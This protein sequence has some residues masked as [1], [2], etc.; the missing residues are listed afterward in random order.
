MA[1]I[2]DPDSLTQGVVLAVADAAFTGSSGQNTVIGG[3]ATLPILA[4]GEWFEVR[5]SPL[6]QNNGLYE[7]TGTPTTSS[8]A[9]TKLGATAPAD[10]TAE[11]VSMLGSSTTPKNVMYDTAARLIYLLEDSGATLSADGLTMLALHSFTKEEWKADA[12]LIAFPFP[13]IGI[14]FDAGKWE[15]GVDPSGNA[16]GWR[17]E[18]TTAAATEIRSRLLVRNAGW[19]ERDSDNNIIKKYFNST[20]LGTF[21]D[22][23]DLAYYAFG[24]QPA[25][26]SSVNYAFT[27]PVNEA[28]KFFEEFGN[29]DTLNFTVNNTITRATGSFLTDGYIVGGGITIRA[30]ATGDHNGTF[31]VSTVAATSLTI[32]TTPWTTGLDTLALLS[33]DNSNA[34]TTFLRIRDADP[35]GKVFAQANL[36]SAGETSLVNKVIKF[37]LGNATDLK[38]TSTDAT[39]TGGGPWDEITLRYMDAVYQRDVDT[40]ATP[41]SFGIVVDVGTFSDGTGTTA[42]TTTFLGVGQWASFNATRTAANFSAGVLRIHE[43]ADA[44]DHIIN[45]TPVDSA[46]DISV[47]ITIA[48]TAAVADISYTLIPTTPIVATAEQIYEKVQWSLRQTTDIDAEDATAV[49]GRTADALLFFVGDAMTAGSVTAPPAN[50]NGGGTGVIIEGFDSNDT[51]RITMVDNSDTS[52]TFPFVAAGTIN[53]NPNLVSDSMGTY[54]MYFTNT[55]E[56]TATTYGISAPTLNVA[57]LD[58]SVVDLDSGEFTLLL[59]DYIVM[60]GWAEETNNGLF[61]VTTAGAGGAGPW[62]AGITK[63]NGDTLVVEAAGASVTLELDPLDSPDA[64]LV[65]DNL[66]ADITGTI[67]GASVAFDFDYDNNV[68]GGRTAATPAKVTVRA[69][70]LETAQSIETTGTI[71]RATGLVFSLVSSLERNYSNP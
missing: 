47:S 63:V 33:V 14:D 37:P 61:Q 64:I 59:G 60:S 13:M 69:I 3:A 40:P 53:F 39:I 19:F 8:I 9:C 45:A 35:E 27:G 68:Q 41:R 17:L 20:T 42:V 36:L 46:G 38:I 18:D 16:N 50:P 10:D 71:T 62:T 23:L 15:F 24:N 2:T 54:W 32:T 43:G 66:V 30:S 67:G 57:T 7:A 5:D 56:S 4:A 48:L 55:A 25:V 51:N 29:A 22:A 6:A 44:G 65:D 52:R 49:V 11:A 70:G 58:S 21:E 1:L 31:V 12:D 34:F 28:V 26:D